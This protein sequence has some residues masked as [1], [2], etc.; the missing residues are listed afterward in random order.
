MSILPSEVRQ[1]NTIGKINM[2]DLKRK[3]RIGIRVSDA[4]LE[5]LVKL[6]ADKKQTKSQWIRDRISQARLK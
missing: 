1:V 3:T 2:S 4:E 5:K 6:A